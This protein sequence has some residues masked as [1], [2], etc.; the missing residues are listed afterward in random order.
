MTMSLKQ[1]IISLAVVPLIAASITSL[2]LSNYVIDTMTKEVIQTI[3][4]QELLDQ[5]AKLKESLQIF[6]TSLEDKNTPIE[7]VVN[8][9]NKTRFGDNGY[10]ILIRTNGRIV[11]HGGDNGLNGTIISDRQLQKL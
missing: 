2:I 1:K 9:V 4:K 6:Y 11:A 7:K 5:K 10:F 3:E 8:L